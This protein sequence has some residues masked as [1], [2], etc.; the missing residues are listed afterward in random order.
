M[1]ADSRDVGYSYL[2]A[3]P[4]VEY[5]GHLQLS[6]LN[7]AD[8]VVTQP[9]GSGLAWA[10]VFAGRTVDKVAIDKD[11]YFDVT[12]SELSGGHLNY[13]QGN[14]HYR[15]GY[16]RLDLDISLEGKLGGVI[17]GL[18]HSGNPILAAIASAFDAGNI[19]EFLSAGVVYDKGPVTTQFMYTTVDQESDSYPDSQH[20]FVSLGYR[21]GRW[22]PYATLAIADITTDAPGLPPEFISG[23]LGELAS[24]GGVVRAGQH[25]VTLGTRYD[26]TDQ[27]ALKFQVDH[28]RVQETMLWR[29][30]EPDWNGRATLVSA[31]LDFVF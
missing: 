12:G 5:F 14:W 21:A 26:V 15:L 10:K 28:S 13:Q 30:V 29:E 4:P 27:L 2:W 25:T 1:L 16:T 24:L 8:L 17:D 23:P 22:T 18:A 6:K 19:Y 20:A 31:T 7:G 11:S 9:L 3:R